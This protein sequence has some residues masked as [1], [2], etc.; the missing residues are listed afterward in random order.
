MRNKLLFWV[1][2][3]LIV[4]S[5]AGPLAQSAISDQPFGWGEFDHGYHIPM[6]HWDHMPQWTD[7]RP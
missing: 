2:V 1:G 7:D 5:V 6:D 4:A 3:A